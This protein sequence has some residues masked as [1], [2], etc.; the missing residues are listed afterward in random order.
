MKTLLNGVN[1][2]LKKTGV[3]D[4]GVTLSTLTDTSKQTFIDSAVQALN[5]VID[6]LYT[7]TR[8][9]KPKQMRSAVITLAQQRSYALHS[10]TIRLRSEYGLIDETNNQTMSVLEE[11]GYR[12]IIHGDIE[13][14]DT[15]LPRFA[16]V[17]PEDGR[18]YLE[19]T[20]TAGLVGRTYKYRYERD[21][22]LD[23][24]TDKFPFNDLVFRAVIPAAAQLWKLNHQQEFNQGLFNASVARAARALRPVPAR[25]SWSAPRGV[26]NAT[27][28]FNDAKVS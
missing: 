20:P 12:R 6:E 19:R 18:L 15:G 23:E 28:P 24:A 2:V 27:D 8:T 11:D 22:E 25:T 17:N 4:S 21:L 1:E 13:Q 16:A 3:L 10:Q 9:P 5:E 7:N 26:P 14:D